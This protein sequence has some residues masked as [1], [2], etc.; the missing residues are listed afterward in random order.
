MP[1]TTAAF[2]FPARE[3][4]EISVDGILAKIPKAKN[5]YLTI[6][7]DG[8]DMSIAPEWRHRCRAAFFSIRNAISL[9][10]S[11]RWEGLWRPT[12]WKLTPC[13]IRRERQAPCIIDDDARIYKDR[14]T[15][16]VRQ[17]RVK[18]VTVY[19]ASLFG[20]AANSNENRG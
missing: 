12:W 6:D 15:E 2:L 3:A 19:R 8:F 9:T 16:K 11:Q 5:Y 20:R 14:G 18:Q 1:E 10:A 7:I 4:A 13:M 17:K